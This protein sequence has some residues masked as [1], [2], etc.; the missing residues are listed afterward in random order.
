[1][2]AETEGAQERRNVMRGRRGGKRNDHMV[3]LGDDD[4]EGDVVDDLE[5]LVS[6]HIAE[7]F[8]GPPPPSPGRVRATCIFWPHDSLL[9]T[10][11]DHFEVHVPI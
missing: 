10:G 6:D 1:M 8:A 7:G 3:Y 9:M 4:L 2:T 11:M 5:I